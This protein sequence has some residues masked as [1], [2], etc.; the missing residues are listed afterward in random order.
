MILGRPGEREEISGAAQVRGGSTRRWGTGGCPPESIADADGVS[1]GGL[2]HGGGYRP[3]GDF[4]AREPCVSTVVSARRRRTKRGVCGSLDG[5]SGEIFEI[6]PEIRTARRASELADGHSTLG[7]AQRWWCRGRTVPR[8]GTQSKACAPGRVGQSPPPPWMGEPMGEKSRAHSAGIRKTTH[9][10]TFTKT[11]H[12][13][14]S[15]TQ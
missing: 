3:G 8:W 11:S 13:S 2:H 7:A 1:A 5:A 10:R 14:P 15:E 4:R 9:L 6:A 12:R